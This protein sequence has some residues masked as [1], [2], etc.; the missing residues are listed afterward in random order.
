[1]I[2]EFAD[3]SRVENCEISGTPRVKDLERVAEPCQ[4]FSANCLKHLEPEGGSRAASRGQR[5]MQQGNSTAQV[6][7]VVLFF[8]NHLCAM[9]VTSDISFFGSLIHS[10]FQN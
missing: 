9:S 10:F 6:D 2:N 4:L 5:A 7:R 3:S 1:M 8:S